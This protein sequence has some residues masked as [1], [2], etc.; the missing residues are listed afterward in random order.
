MGV[1]CIKFECCVGRLIGI[2]LQKMTWNILLFFID[3][4]MRKM[5]NKSSSTNKNFYKK[6][7]YTI[8]EDY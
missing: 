3:N 8:E 7:Y 4:V 2:W 1:S 6:K 5:N